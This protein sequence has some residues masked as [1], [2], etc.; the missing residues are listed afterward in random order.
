MI[1]VL[2]VQHN[3]SIFVPIRVVLSQ[4]SDQ[5]CIALQQSVA[6]CR[7]PQSHD[8]DQGGTLSVPER[9]PQGAVSRRRFAG[10]TPSCCGYQPFMEGDIGW[11][12]T[13]SSTL[14]SSKHLLYPR[15]A[16]WGWSLLYHMSLLPLPYEM[17]ISVHICHMMKLMPKV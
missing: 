11:P 15:Q 9:T 7:L 8:L 10:N 4:L 6:G 1:L 13:V 12:V 16:L 2:G 5:V 3:D 17:G 14:T